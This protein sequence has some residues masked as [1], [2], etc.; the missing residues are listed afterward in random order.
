MLREGVLFINEK[1][2]LKLKKNAK[3]A[4]NMESENKLDPKYKTEMCK[5]W[6]ETKFCVY[7]NKC[8][9]AHG[10]QELFGRSSTGSNYKLKDCNS[11]RENGICM[12]GARCNFK[13]DERRLE[14]MERSYYSLLPAASGVRRLP[15]F[16]AFSPSN[17]PLNMSDEVYEQPKPLLMPHFF[18]MGHHFGGAQF[19]P[20]TAFSPIMARLY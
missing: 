14:G 20:F 4:V 11:F 10:K 19:V 13:H 15:V 8:R 7:G 5:S 17:S 9:F 3:D 6:A 2:N 16:E 1:R 12:Y 18:N